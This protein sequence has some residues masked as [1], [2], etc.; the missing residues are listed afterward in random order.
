MSRT[1]VR[2]LGAVAL[3]TL[4]QAVAQMVCGALLMRDAP[5]PPGNFLAW[6]L[7]VQVLTAVFALVLA[8]NFQAASPL[9]ALVLFAVFFGI[10]ANY[11][12]EAF[13]FDIGVGRPMLV[14]L[15]AMSLLAAAVLALV[16]DRLSPRAATGASPAVPGWPVRLLGGALAY[17]VF[18]F[19]V[20]MAAIPFIADFYAGRAMPPF[21]ELIAVQLVRGLAFAGVAWL[22]ASFVP[23]SRLGRAAWAGVTLSV[24]GGVIPL[25][26]PNAF[27]PDYVRL[28]HLAEVGVSNFLFGLVAGLLLTAAGPAS[29]RADALAASH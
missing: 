13:F 29:A 12:A 3:L 28:V 8:R 27:L 4:A 24:V 9:R 21:P 19:A 23:G 5:A 11:L 25:L 10:P 6:A 2:W 15:Y 18:Y 16:A 17:V 20:G 1:I 7:L 26:A 14:R 22:V